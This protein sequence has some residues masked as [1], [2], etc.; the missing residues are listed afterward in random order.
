MSM[1]AGTMATD[2]PHVVVQDPIDRAIARLEQIRAHAAD[3]ETELAT[4]DAIRLLA[5][6]EPATVSDHPTMSAIK[7]HLLNDLGALRHESGDLEGSRRLL[8]AALELSPENT[9][10]RANLGAVQDEMDLQVMPARRLRGVDT[11]FRAWAEW[12]PGALQTLRKH[13][14]VKGKDVLEI[15]A[16]V[17]RLVVP[18]LRTKTWVSCVSVG[19]EQDLP[20]DVLQADLAELP[21][22]DNSFDAVFSVCY[23][24]HMDELAEILDEVERVL[25]PGGALVF[26]FSPIWSCARGHHL[27]LEC[28]SRDPL[29][30]DHAVIPAW[31]HLLLEKHELLAYLNHGLGDARAQRAVDFIYGD[32]HLSHMSEADYQHTFR[33]MELEVE[34]LEHWGGVQRPRPGIKAELERVHPGAGR[35]DVYGFTGVFHKRG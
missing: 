20:D 16:A 33:H 30:F 32:E 2:A 11:P 25:R 24:E 10:A 19:E 28:N 12:T 3:G 1:I 31:A 17:P 23:L 26:Q 9:L 34:S 4:I 29:S 13:V 14:G 35:F 18:S 21:F 5:S 27:R 22:A 15:G 7:V 8:Q 6:L